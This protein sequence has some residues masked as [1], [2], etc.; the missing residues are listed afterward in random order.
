MRLAIYHNLPSGGA[1]RAM[2]EYSRRLATSHT[3]ELYQLDHTDQL[4]HTDAGG[5]GQ[6][7]LERSVHGVHPYGVAGFGS[8]SERGTSLRLPAYLRRLD[9]VQRDVAHD[10]DAGG[11][12][13]ALV[14]PCRVTQTPGILSM[15]QTPTVYYMQEP[16]RASF[17]HAFRAQP[18]G[19]GP[20]SAARW[21]MRALVER[22]LRSIDQRAAGAAGLVLANS[23]YSIESIYRAYGLDA[24]FCPLGADENVFRLSTVA[25]RENR[26]LSVGALVPHKGH[27]LV[28]AGASGVE[29]SRRPRVGI[30]CNR[31]VSGW[32]AHL[33]RLAEQLDV[34]LELHHEISDDRLAHLYQS[35]IATFCAARLEPFGLSA[36]ESLCCG[37]PVIAVR[38]GGFREIVADG[39]NG[40]LVDRNPAEAAAAVVAVLDGTLGTDPSK[41]RASVLPAWSWDRAATKLESIV[42]GFVASTR[43]PGA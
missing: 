39:V 24:T 7:A 40:M 18:V 3:V 2:Q 23:Y 33:E 1:L 19:P 25:V 43:G 16:R 15:L 34:R 29:A 11:Y 32:G 30:V 35:S 28:I 36:L 37:T 17:E 42:A 5:P 12:D 22:R 26:L 27:E 8:G 14:H 6:A 20:T 13:A 38:E 9:A 21:C 31:A 10:I 4:E 41:L